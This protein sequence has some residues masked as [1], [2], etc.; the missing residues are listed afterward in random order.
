MK[1]HSLLVI[2]FSIL[3]L[4]GP[5]TPSFAGEGIV[6]TEDI[7]LKLG[8][9]FMAEGEYYRAV[10]EFMKFLI[11]FPASPKGDYALF[12][13]GMAYFRGDEYKKA[14]DAFASVVERYGGSASAAA[15]SFY[16][17]VSYARLEMYDLAGKA[18]DSVVQRY[19]SSEYAPTALMGKSLLMIGQKDISGSR[20]ELKSF[21]ASYPDDTRVTNVR[22][23]IAQ[24]DLTG[25]LPRKSPILA[26]IMSAVIPGS[27]HIYA[28]H[29]GDGLT[30]LFLNGLF[31]AGTVV[32]VKQENYAVAGIVGVIGMPFYLGNIYGAA[33][34]ATKWNLGVSRDLQGKI[35][36]TLDYRF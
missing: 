28:G 22:D 32:A 5:A 34:A 6:I 11:L 19:P 14:A 18:F 36:V 4:V 35:A 9:A 20:R 33:N 13:I 3:L 24:I 21:L 17:G 26:G 8:D 12:N 23:A 10:T 25:D 1:K 31:I 29:Y 2:L 16:E 30:S 15:A 7:Q 27:G